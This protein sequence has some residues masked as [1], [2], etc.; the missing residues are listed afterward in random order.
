M[1]GA[2]SRPAS[3]KLPLANIYRRRETGFGFR[4]GRR[5]HNHP[6]ARDASTTGFEK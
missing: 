2:E 4:E 1:N 3:F 5:K 6:T